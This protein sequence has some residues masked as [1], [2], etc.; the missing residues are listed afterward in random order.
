MATETQRE[1]R[2]DYETK[3][4]FWQA[5]K[6]RYVAHAFMFLTLFVVLA[7]LTWM[8]LTSMKPNDAVFSQTY[9]P[10]T[11]FQGAVEACGSA[12]VTKGHWKAAMNSFVIAITST[13]IVMALG[14]PAG[15]VFSRYR[16]RFDDAM[17][18]L[19]IVTRLFPRSD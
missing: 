2:I 19:V 12:L 18:L 6:S 8:F 16:F 13:T 10:T 11:P 17:F 9:L 7:P 5:V 4:R 15:Y 1:Q 14:T 3:K